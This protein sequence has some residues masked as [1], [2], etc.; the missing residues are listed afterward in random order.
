MEAEEEVADA[1]S[2]T[3]LP[4]ARIKHPKSVENGEFRGERVPHFPS[5]WFN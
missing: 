2:A 5:S 3:E 1:I 4:F